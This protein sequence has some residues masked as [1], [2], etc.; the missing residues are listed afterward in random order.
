MTLT[1]ESR[2]KQN[3]YGKGV[4][5]NLVKIIDAEDISNTQPFFLNS[6]IDIGVKLTLN[7]GREDFFPELSI[8]GQFERDTNTNEIIGWGNSFCT[9]EL[10]YKLGFRGHLKDNNE[11]PNEAIELLKGKKF[12]KLAYV[13][14]I[15]DDGNL[16]Y[17]NWNL[18]A[19][20]EEDPKTLADRFHKSV[21]S[22]YPRNYRPELVDIFE[23][24]IAEEV[25]QMI[26]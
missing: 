11:I 4:Y 1:T 16:K 12:Y 9:Q 6:P 24:S 7:I 10:F 21:N 22:G 14:G 8:F 17:S 23:D 5:I 20:E 15:K 2:L 3:L 25:N 26:Y 19:A 13:S 18:I